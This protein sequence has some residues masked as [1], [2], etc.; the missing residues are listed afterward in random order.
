MYLAGIGFSQI[1]GIVGGFLLIFVVNV[2][3][4]L[5]FVADI[6]R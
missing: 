6:E 4:Y 1:A 5:Q 2:L 3:I